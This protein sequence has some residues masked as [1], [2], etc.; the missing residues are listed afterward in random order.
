MAWFRPDLFGRV[1]AYSTT[2][3]AQQN[4]AQAA[5]AAKYPHGAWDYHSDLQVIMNDMTG[6]EKQLRIFIN[7]ND[8]DN[9]YNAPVSGRHNWLIANQRTAAALMA[10]SFHYRFVTGTG[11]GHCAPAV[12][13]ATL[14]DSLVWAWR[15]YQP[16]GI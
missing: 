3:V 1:I 5:D 16:S 10:K 14:A 9:G 15:G 8:N 7:A 4:S 2:L 6:R 11:L 13:S 12:R